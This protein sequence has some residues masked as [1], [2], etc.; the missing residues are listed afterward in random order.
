[1]TEPSQSSNRKA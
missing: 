1:M